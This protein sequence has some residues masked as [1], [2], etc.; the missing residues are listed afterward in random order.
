[1]P[2]RSARVRVRG[3]E[4]KFLCR[5]ATALF[6]AK[7]LVSLTATVR[8][9]L[10]SLMALDVSNVSLYAHASRDFFIERPERIP[11]ANQE[12]MWGG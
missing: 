7:L 2:I 1:M 3:P 6:S 8:Q 10:W 12:T 4:D 9:R 5:D 11:E